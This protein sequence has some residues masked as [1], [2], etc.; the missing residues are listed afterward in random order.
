[1]QLGSPVARALAGARAAAVR[2]VRGLGVLELRGD[3]EAVVL[4][5]GEEL[6]R[7]TP[8]RGLLLAEGSTADRRTR[9]RAAG[10]RVYDLTAARAAL[11]VEGE[12][13]L[14]RLTDLDLDRLPAVGAV[15]RGVTALVQRTGPDTFRLLV[16]Q[17]L[18]HYVAEVA[19]DM[20]EGLSR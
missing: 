7:I 4:E 9:L 19:L 3:L 16:P 17:E 2:E 14:R 5:P 20:A 18:A 10:L 11:E 12:Q 15:A 1:M 13:V 8:A 6:I